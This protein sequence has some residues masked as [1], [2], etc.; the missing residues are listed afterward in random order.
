MLTHCFLIRNADKDH[1]AIA[2]PPTKRRRIGENEDMQDMQDMQGLQG[3]FV[4]SVNL[5][6]MLLE[7]LNYNPITIITDFRPNEQFSCIF[8]HAA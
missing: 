5:W 2:S 6:L 4:K 1:K 3:P 7:V 8:E